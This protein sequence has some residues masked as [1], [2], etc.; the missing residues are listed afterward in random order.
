MPIAPLALTVHMPEQ[1]SL[2]RLH[3]SPT[4][5]HQEAP[6]W[7]LPA[8][9]RFEQQLEL[10]VQ[11]LP[12]VR[13]AGLSA[14]QLPPEQMPL[15]QSSACAHVCPSDTHAGR[16]QTPLVHASP[17][18]SVGTVQASPWPRQVLIVAVQTPELASQRPVQQSEA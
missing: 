11:A 5:M 16:P 3:A 2:S 7:H 13:Q 17:Q 15:Q 4:W 9:Q 12:A 10:L 18:Q 1:Q 8:L 14:W 6:S